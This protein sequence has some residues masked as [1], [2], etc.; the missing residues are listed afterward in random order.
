MTK[1]IAAANAPKKNVAKV[2][3]QRLVKTADKDKQ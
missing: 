3:S 1:K 2:A